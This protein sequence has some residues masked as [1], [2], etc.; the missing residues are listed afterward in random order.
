MPRGPVDAPVLLLGEGP[1]EVED[2][3]GEAF[4]GPSGKLLDIILAEV[5]AVARIYNI[6]Q[7][8]PSDGRREANRAPTPA[9]V[10]ACTPYVLAEARRAPR[11]AVVFAGEVAERY[12]R[13][14]WPDGHRM[15]HPAFLLRTGGRA[16]PHYAATVRALRE[17]LERMG[18]HGGKTE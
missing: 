17:Y 12:Y 14:E 13:H 5:G 7:C 11:V 18:V 4:V 10:L 9:E 8:R 16:A 15:L 1:G 3:L 6:V 2:V